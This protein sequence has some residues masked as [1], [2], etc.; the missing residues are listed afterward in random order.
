MDTTKSEP[1][2]TKEA[3]ENRVVRACYGTARRLGLLTRTTGNGFRAVGKFMAAGPQLVARLARAI[4]RS[5][6]KGESL[7]G[8]KGIRSIVLEELLRWQDA[9]GKPNVAEL[10]ER[11]RLMTETIEALQSRI[12]ELSDRGSISPADMWE[13]ISSLEVADSLTDDE[14]AL[15]VSVFRHNVALQKRKFAGAALDEITP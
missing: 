2:S 6:G 5:P 8:R 4:Q 1:A 13:E 7:P 3:D 14:R 12:G 15:L 9:D 11:L 10:E